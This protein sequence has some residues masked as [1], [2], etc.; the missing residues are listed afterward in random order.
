MSTASA[1]R[2]VEAKRNRSSIEATKQPSKAKRSESR[3]IAKGVKVDKGMEVD[4]DSARTASVCS[5]STVQQ[6]T[7]AST[8]SISSVE[9]GNID[10]S[11]D[12]PMAGEKP[13]DLL[14]RLYEMWPAQ[15]TDSYRPHVEPSHLVTAESNLRCI[16]ERQAEQKRQ[17]E[18]DRG[19]KRITFRGS[20]CK[21]TAAH[22]LMNSVFYNMGKKVQ[23]THVLSRCR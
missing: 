4:K 9:R 17:Q 21:V 7:T 20:V 16:R 13:N 6:N 8:F 1:P 14:R 23:I 18:E 2:S 19:V 15:L 12:S 3:V 22:K 5:R 11:P 10:I